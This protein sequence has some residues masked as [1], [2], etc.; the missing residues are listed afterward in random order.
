MGTI[1]VA[2]CTFADVE[3]P[4]AVD[5]T[6]R[7]VAELDLL[8]LRDIRGLSVSPDGRHV[9]FQLQQA[10]LDTNGYEL[11]WF[12]SPTSRSESARSVGD[13]GNPIWV[14]SDGGIFGGIMFG[15][16]A[17]RA[18]KW[19]PDGH[20]IAYLVRHDLDVQ[21]WRS[22]VD[23]SSQKQ[24]T[25]N[26][27]EV[28]DFA[29]SDDGSKIVF[30]VDDSR[31]QIEQALREEGE[32]GYLVD[33]RYMPFYSSKPLLPPSEF[34][35]PKPRVWA[36]DVRTGEERLATNEEVMIFE[37]TTVRSTAT[38]PANARVSARSPDG[39]TVAWAEPEPDHRDAIF[40]P[41]LSLHAAGAAGIESV[42]R[43]AD[44]RCSGRIAS[45]WVSPNKN[46][47]YF[48]RGEGI[49]YATT[50]LY[51]WALQADTVRLIRRT[52]DLLASCALTSEGLVC[53]HESALTPQKI[54]SIDLLTG[55]IA[56][57]VDPN[58]EFQHLDK[59]SATKIFWKSREYD[60]EAFGHLVLPPNYESGRRYP[61][62]ITT[63]DS[64]GFL[65]GGV[66]DEYPI[67]VFAA[68]GFVVLDFDAP[69]DR[70][71]LAT[72][73][74]PQEMERATR[75]GERRHKQVKASLDAAIDLLVEMELVDPHRIALTGLSFGS[76]LTLYNISRPN[77]RFAVAA[78]SSPSRDPLFYY[79]GGIRTQER[80]RSWGYGHPAG[81]DAQRWAEHSVSSNIGVIGT[82]LLFQASDSEYLIALEA[83]A[84]MR[85]A[86]KPFELY[87][88]PDEKHIKMQPKHRYHVYR[89]NVQWM[90]FWLQGLEAK[91]PVDPKQYTRW[92]VLRDQ[93]VDNFKSAGAEYT[94]PL[95][96][97]LATSSNKEL[98]K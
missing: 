40:S 89:R 38:D 8:Q 32:R 55:D 44:S 35:S 21:I 20:W 15:T 87:V 30:T 69:V 39:Y 17:T 93:H 52:D 45:I 84:A 9:A 90:Q 48:M 25:H 1:T 76:E 46:D 18:P 66:G 96:I 19:S 88:F 24:V 12:V 37:V 53:T 64:R 13:G 94:L 7:P 97:N 42:R 14:I 86:R 2:T 60:Q 3:R 58:P 10:N 79:L 47:V 41:P 11:A 26:S 51:V 22:A 31:T 68:N 16:S 73:T 36:L 43:C 95:P 23:G 71:L 91:H 85:E 27:D 67:Q 33:E 77:N 4:S 80:L 54:V 6:R 83:F 5:N 56:T 62:I 75:E 81:V 70:E 78:A 28:A 63:Y 59:G 61:L 49:G 98:L 82:P 29:W 50:G 74:S 65:R 92:R 34:R 57:L 72:A